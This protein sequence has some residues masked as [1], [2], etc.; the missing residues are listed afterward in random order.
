MCRDD[1]T[2]Q[3]GMFVIQGLNITSESWETGKVVGDLKYLPAMVSLLWE[4]FE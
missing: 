4:M 1:I 2:K 3:E